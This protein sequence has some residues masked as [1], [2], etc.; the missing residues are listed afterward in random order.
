MLFS[1]LLYCTLVQF[2]PPPN[3]VPAVGIELLNFTSTLLVQKNT[4]IDANIKCRC[5][6]KVFTFF[7]IVNIIEVVG[8]ELKT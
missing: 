7:D 1:C 5:H 4:S 2:P 3:T 8:K 6:K